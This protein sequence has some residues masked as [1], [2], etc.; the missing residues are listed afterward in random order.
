MAS[1]GSSPPRVGDSALLLRYAEPSEGFAR[2]FPASSGRRRELW[3]H[4]DGGSS[5]RKGSSPPREGDRS[6]RKEA[7]EFT[8]LRKAVPRLERETVPVRPYSERRGASG[9]R[10][11][12]RQFPA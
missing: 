3:C 1:Q 6:R 12:A 9:C 2:P 4:G 5:C 7:R 8:R 10:S 11:V